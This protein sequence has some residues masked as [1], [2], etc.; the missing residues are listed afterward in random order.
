MVWAP[1]SRVPRL[2][3]AGSA[4]VWI[5]AAVVEAHTSDLSGLL[6]ATAGILLAVFAWFGTPRR[7]AAYAAGA[8]GAWRIWDLIQARAQGLIGVRFADE[9]L[10]WLMF[11]VFTVI[12]VALNWRIAND[13]VRSVTHD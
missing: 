10:V 9:T 8:A 2:L 6:Y 7:A 1:G 5:A 13:I 4:A 11:T 12:L 3:V